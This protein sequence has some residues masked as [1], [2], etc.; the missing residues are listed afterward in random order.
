MSFKL[1]EDLLR[2]AIRT[3]YD[4]VAVVVIEYI[5]FYGNIEEH[6]M[7]E[8]LN[9]P[10][11]QVRQA[12]LELNMH[13]ILT[14]KE[15]KKDRRHEERSGN[16]F[17]RGPDLGRMVYWTFDPDIKN[18]LCCRIL[19]LRK[20][21]DEL[22]DEA[23]K[24]VYTCPICNRNFSIEE[25]IPDFVCNICQNSA[26]LKKESSLGEAKLKRQQGLQQIKH[27]EALMR[28]CIDV[29]LPSSFFGTITESTDK[30]GDKN[31]NVRLARTTTGSRGFII[32]INLPEAEIEN[33]EQA[34]VNSAHDP[35]LF[36]YY[37][38]FEKKTK[39][40]KNDQG[41][42]EEFKANGIAYS[43]KE[44]TALLQITMNEPEF[45]KYFEW[46]TSSFLFL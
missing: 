26:L 29:T 2:I 39:K 27:M 46:K 6:K 20:A 42:Q 15:G 13:Q 30:P 12:L 21:L 34:S 4:E 28:E 45:K 22:L 17:T 3:F 24:V 9:L 19:Y 38:K 37:Q 33:K 41:P 8:D 31:S 1:F 32:N 7:S 18:V 10:F 35:D 25:A 11:K 16:M 40:K 43:G 5:L 23:N 14:Y 36:K 44:I